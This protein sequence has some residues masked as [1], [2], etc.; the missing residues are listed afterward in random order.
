MSD[1]VD[2]GRLS[3]ALHGAARRVL[4]GE[5]GGVASVVWLYVSDAASPWHFDACGAWP[6]SV[7][8]L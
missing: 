6:A 5:E 8:R 7:D 4:A 3:F 2:V 1:S